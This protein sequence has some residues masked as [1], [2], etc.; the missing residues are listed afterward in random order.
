MADAPYEVGYLEEIIDVN[1]AG[2]RWAV[3]V[4]QWGIALGD[5]TGGLI[6][7]PTQKGPTA[8]F[9][10][11]PPVGF[12]KGPGS[13][14]ATYPLTSKDHLSHKLF[15]GEAFVTGWGVFSNFGAT[16]F[17]NI[18]IKLPAK[19]FD[20]FDIKIDL[21][22]MPG[23]VSAGGSAVGVFTVADKILKVGSK[24]PVFSPVFGPVTGFP[25]ITDQKSK[26]PGGTD[27]SAKHE[28]FSISQALK[29]TMTP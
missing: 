29:V 24:V 3:A 21:G 1:F 16:K 7:T 27:S 8:F 25:A 17:V 12:Y 18:W 10:I 22:A 2:G 13:L 5:P 20:S 19:I 6:A 23:G 28:S 4:V 15:T 9:P 26:P 14:T 11:T